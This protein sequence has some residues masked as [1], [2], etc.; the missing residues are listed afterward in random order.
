[1]I[2][3]VLYK[4]LTFE[5]PWEVVP[6][7]R[8]RFARIGGYVRTYTD[9]K[10]HAFEESVGVIAQAAMQ[11]QGFLRV[12]ADEGSVAVQIRCFFEPPKRWPARRRKLLVT[13]R[14]PM[15]KKPDVDNAAKSILDGMNGIVYDDDALISSLLVEKWYAEKAR[16]QIKVSF[17]ADVE[18]LVKHDEAER[19]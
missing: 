8:P 3:N 4:D 6:K 11:K 13:N 14:I 2:E 9:K 17:T 19:N 5:I 7:G 18:E 15:T 12:G 1:M 16:V 10:T